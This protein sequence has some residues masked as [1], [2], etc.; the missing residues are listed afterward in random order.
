MK[1]YLEEGDDCPVE[2]CEGKMGYEPVENCACHISPPCRACET[3]P[4][5]CLECGLEA[6]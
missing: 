2:D 1:D 5:V 3:N 4:L 6:E